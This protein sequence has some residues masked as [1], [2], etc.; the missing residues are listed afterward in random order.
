VLRDQ[1]ALFGEV[2]STPTAWR[3]LE[4]VDDDALDRIATARAEARAKAWAA[5]ADPGFYVVDVDATLVTSHCMPRDTGGV[6]R[7]PT[8]RSGLVPVLDLQVEFDA[9]EV[10]GVV[11]GEE[12]VHG[13]GPDESSRGNQY[14]GRGDSYDCLRQRLEVGGE[15]F[16]D[17]R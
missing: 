3:T 10:D 7:L 4:A 1:P 14:P 9:D 16:D 13:D 5:G 8:E 12:P 15:A 11:G 6:Q 17:H 2:A